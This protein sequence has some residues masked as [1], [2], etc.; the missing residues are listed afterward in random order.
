VTPGGARG[1]RQTLIEISQFAFRGRR[2]VMGL[3]L[4]GKTRH[5]YFVTLIEP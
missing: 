5:P 1:G 2:W 4:A 3:R